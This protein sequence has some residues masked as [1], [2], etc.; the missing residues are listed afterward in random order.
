[1]AQLYHVCG[2]DQRLCGPLLGRGGGFAE[3]TAVPQ[4]LVEVICQ[5]TEMPHRPWYAYRPPLWH[6]H[7]Q[8]WTRRRRRRRHSRDPNEPTRSLVRLLGMPPT[9]A[10]RRC[11]FTGYVGDGSPNLFIHSFLGYA[12]YRIIDPVTNETVVEGH[13]NGFCL[14][15]SICP[16]PIN[17]TYDWSVW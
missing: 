17:G 14:M 11:V 16:N 9:L 2:Q 5:L 4:T 6:P 12:D 13:K 8:P 15:D 10:L 7:P 1:M 3:K